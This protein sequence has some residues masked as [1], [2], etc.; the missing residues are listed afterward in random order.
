MLKKEL[1]YHKDSW[2]SPTGV[3]SP[4]SLHNRTSHGRTSLNVHSDPEYDVA[5]S[6]ITSPKKS[7]TEE[8][9][10]VVLSMKSADSRGNS[11]KPVTRATLV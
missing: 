4:L 3:R 1:Q 9:L 2:K 7:G 11:N 10:G 5:V 6:E 8:K